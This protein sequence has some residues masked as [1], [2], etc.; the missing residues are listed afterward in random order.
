[1]LKCVSCFL[2]LLLFYLQ[3]CFVFLGYLKTCFM[4]FGSFLLKRILF[5]DMFVLNVFIGPRPLTTDGAG[6]R[7]SR[8]PPFG[9]RCRWT[10]GAS[11]PLGGRPRAHRLYPRPASPP[12]VGGLGSQ[13]LGFETILIDIDQHNEVCKLSGPLGASSGSLA[14]VAFCAWRLCADG[15][16]AN[17][18]CKLLGASSGSS[19]E[20]AKYA[21][22]WVHPR[23]HRRHRPPASRWLEAVRRCTS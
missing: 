23:P 13:G 12:V 14:A 21:S 11:E 19:V 15:N 1:M 9:V 22:S 8:W 5:Y 2:V 10:V 3:M 4:L 20:S 18:A 16:D 7:C 6:S 17:Q